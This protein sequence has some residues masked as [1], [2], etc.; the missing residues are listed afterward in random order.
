MTVTPRAIPEVAY[1]GPRSPSRLAI[2]RRLDST[3][4]KFLVQTA[5][6]PDRVPEQVDQLEQGRDAPV[7]VRQ[8][9]LGQSGY[10]PTNVLFRATGERPSG[11]TRRG[12]TRG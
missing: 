2:L 10:V 7:A 3:G 6:M 8:G 9:S 12:Y 1:L 11:S 4:T 5:Q